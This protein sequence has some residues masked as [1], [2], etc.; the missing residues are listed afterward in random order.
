L[1]R[2]TSGTSHRSIRRTDGSTSPLVSVASSTARSSGLPVP[3]CPAHPC[4]HGHQIA[5]EPLRHFGSHGGR[6]GC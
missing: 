3:R 2:P 5:R 1:P 4:S 6:A